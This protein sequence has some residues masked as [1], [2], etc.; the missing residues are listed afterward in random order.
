MLRVVTDRF[1]RLRVEAV[2]SGKSRKSDDQ[3]SK[4]LSLNAVFCEYANGARV[5]HSGFY[6]TWTNKHNVVHGQG[7][8]TRTDAEK[9]KHGWLI[10]KI[11]AIGEE[12]KRIPKKYNVTLYT[13]DPDLLDTKYRP[14][15]KIARRFAAACGD[16]GVSICQARPESQEFKTAQSLITREINATAIKDHPGLRLRASSAFHPPHRG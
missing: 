10:A 3:S 5:L 15:S 14:D 12:L 1:G 11:D 4:S 9:G 2:A 13:D 16:R 6:S 7:R 8:A